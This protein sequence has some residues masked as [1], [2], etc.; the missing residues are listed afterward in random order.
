[1]CQAKQQPA[2]CWGEP[3][4][5]VPFAGGPSAAAAMLT[6]LPSALTW[7]HLWSLALPWW[8]ILL[9]GRQIQHMLICFKVFI[10]S[11]LLGSLGYGD[12][13]ANL[14]FSFPTSYSN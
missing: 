4:S 10:R 12:L 9:A 14:I 6:L 1:M 8:T 7:N 13:M 5:L 2:L 3:I 11:N